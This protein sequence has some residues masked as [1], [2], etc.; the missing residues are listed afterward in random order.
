MTCPKSSGMDRD[1]PEDT[2][3]EAPAPG[4]TL[5][6]SG[7]T[8]QSHNLAGA[9]W[10]DV[11]VSSSESGQARPKRR[12]RPGLASL[13]EG[14]SSSSRSRSGAVEDRRRKQ[15]GPSGCLASTNRPWR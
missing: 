9:C 15:A 13:A 12:R 14:I 1:I 7:G 3:K 2:S 6:L 4:G 10:R 8:L 11:P 5:R